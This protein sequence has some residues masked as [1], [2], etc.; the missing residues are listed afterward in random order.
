MLTQVSKKNIYWLL[1]ITSAFLILAN[2]KTSEASRRYSN[3]HQKMEQSLVEMR[4]V[5]LYGKFFYV[6]INRDEKTIV[7]KGECD[8]NKGKEE[9]VEHFMLRSPTDYQVTFEIAVY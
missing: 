7:V 3:L 5:E 2:I 9:V 8:N 4:I 1:I 6:F